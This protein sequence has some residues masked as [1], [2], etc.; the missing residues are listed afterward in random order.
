MKKQIK[1]LLICNS[2]MFIPTVMTE[3]LKCP[4][5]HYL[6]I[7]DIKSITQFFEF[8]SF[9][10]IDYV[11]YGDEKGRFGFLRQK[12]KLNNVIRQYNIGEV[13]FFH[14]EWGEVANWLI[15]KLS[16]DVPIKYCKIYDSIPAPRSDNWKEVVRIKLLQKIWWGVDVDVLKHS[17]AFPSLPESFYKKVH[18]ETIQLPVDIELVTGYV[19]K[20]LG[21][22]NLDAENVLLTGTIVTDGL[23]EASF[24]TELTN[25]I[26][27]IVG[28]DRLVSKCHP[29]FKDLYGKENELPQ[30]PSFIPGN[31]LIN[32]YNCFI[33]YESTLLVEAAVAGKKSISMMNFLEISEDAK[34]RWV[35]F[36]DSRLQGKGKI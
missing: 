9:Q 15:K 26:I 30:V 3:L 34:R 29:R 7:S 11:E 4:Q 10:N 17:K 20:K 12:E 28:K 16:K 22:E 1:K 19:A 32:N 6:V 13:V 5:N 33:G 21:G 36:F 18:A 24:Y 8:M 14:A 35:D 25:K 23:A 31:V 27:E 2:N